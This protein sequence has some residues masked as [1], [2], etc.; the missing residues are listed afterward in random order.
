MMR[1]QS[2][3]AKVEM[4]EEIAGRARSAAGAPAGFA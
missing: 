4:E 1:L 2:A 3:E